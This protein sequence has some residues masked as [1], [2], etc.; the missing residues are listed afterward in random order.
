MMILYLI[1]KRLV[2]N[3]SKLKI[4]IPAG[5]YSIY[6]FNQKL[7]VS[8]PKWVS[9]KI[10]AGKLI[11]PEHHTF[12][13][14]TPLFD[15]LGITNKSIIIKRK[16]SLYK[17]EYQTS[18]KPPPKKV[19]LYCEEIDK[20]HNKIDR[21]PSTQLFSVDIK[22]DVVHYA[23]LNPVYLP[24]TPDSHSALHLVL[25]DENHRNVTPKAFNLVLLYNKHECI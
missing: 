17:G 4:T 18:L 3:D 13:A 24:L 1:S 7:K 11:I 21:Q 25:L 14:S 5:T 15:A 6:E 9:P 16:F 2:A 19:T 10:E 8:K 22:N 23:P 20:F 12:V